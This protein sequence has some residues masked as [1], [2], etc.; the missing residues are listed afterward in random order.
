MKK[1]LLFLP[2]LGIGLLSQAQQPLRDNT[3]KMYMQ[4]K[5]LQNIL[6]QET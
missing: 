5:L 6:S 2:V 3:M 4:D 1:L